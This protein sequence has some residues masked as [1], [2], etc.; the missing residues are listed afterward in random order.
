MTR[1][2][3]ETLP[4]YENEGRFG[5]T[6]GSSSSALLRAIPDRAEYRRFVPLDYRLDAK[7]IVGKLAQDLQKLKD[8]SAS[9]LGAMAKAIFNFASGGNPFSAMLG[10]LTGALKNIPGGYL[11]AAQKIAASEAARGFAHGAVAGADG[12]SLAYIR[13]MFGS[14][15][16][17]PNHMFEYG[18]TIAIA[19]YRAGLLAGYVQGR[20]L[21]KNQRAI[22]WRD[23]QARMGDQSF[24]GPS[25]QWSRKQWSDWYWEVGG[26]FQRYHLVGT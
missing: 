2:A 25:S 5:T 18:R 20:S 19:N 13:E 6:T 26:I 1:L 14:R 7:A 3:F 23:L 15:Y 10:I 8:P 4:L 22:F 12:R 17:P 21:S 9:Q 11:G 16:F 24:R